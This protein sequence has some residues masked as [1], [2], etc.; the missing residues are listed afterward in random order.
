MGYTT[1]F[2]GVL[3]F[4]HDPSV[5]ELKELKKYL[6]E[7]MRVLDA[8]YAKKHDCTYIDLEITDDFAGIKW[9]GAE[10]CYGMVESVNWLIARMRATFPDFGL[11]GEF[12]AQGEEAEDHWMLIMKD[13]KAVKVE[14]PPPGIKVRCPECEHVFYYEPEEES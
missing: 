7:D 1:T 8:P 9:S 14:K 4:D 12:E 13:G 2:K 11:V 10:K 6:G 3:K 5:P